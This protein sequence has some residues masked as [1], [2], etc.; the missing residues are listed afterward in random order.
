MNHKLKKDFL[1]EIKLLYPSN[2]VYIDYNDDEQGILIIN[3]KYSIYEIELSSLYYTNP[4]GD[5][6]IEQCKNIFI[7][8][9]RQYYLE[10][11]F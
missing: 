10:E 1:D 11:L 9:K 5:L 6:I 3:S 4:E 2:I 8:Y 7:Q